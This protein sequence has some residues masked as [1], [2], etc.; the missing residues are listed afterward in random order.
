MPVRPGWI[1]V[2]AVLLVPV[3]VSVV[4]LYCT[5]GVLYPTISIARGV[6]TPHTVVDTVLLVP[7]DVLLLVET[8][9]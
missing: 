8:T 5:H 1:V 7:V 9:Q 4:A 3:E 6:T 2:Y